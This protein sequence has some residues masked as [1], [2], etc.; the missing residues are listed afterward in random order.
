MKY[1]VKVTVSCVVEATNPDEAHD[2]AIIQA[3]CKNRYGKMP[4][5]IQSI[6]AEV[7]QKGEE[8]ENNAE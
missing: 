5:C 7:I 2:T 6:D 3:V 8:H 1:Q 4:S